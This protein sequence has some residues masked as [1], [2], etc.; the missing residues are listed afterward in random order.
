MSKTAVDKFLKSAIQGF[1]DFCRA[2]GFVK[3]NGEWLNA[4][5]LKAEKA[6]K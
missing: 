1:E 4:D 6:A 2:A 5:D 3:V